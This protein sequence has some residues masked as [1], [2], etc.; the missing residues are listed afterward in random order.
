MVLFKIGGG[1]VVPHIPRFKLEVE[2]LGE[3]FP[4]LHLL[5]RGGDVSDEYYF[6]FFSWTEAN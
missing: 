1:L 6:K 3:L 2:I 4:L 5:T